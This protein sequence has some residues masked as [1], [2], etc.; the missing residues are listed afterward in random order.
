MVVIIII[1]A[2]N[3]FGLWMCEALIDVIIL[4]GSEVADTSQASLLLVILWNYLTDEK[5]IWD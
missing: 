4:D 2:N 1:R 3:Y 5:Q